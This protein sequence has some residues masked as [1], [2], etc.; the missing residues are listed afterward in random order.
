MNDSGLYNLRL[1]AK[2]KVLTSSVKELQFAGENALVA[3]SEADLQN[4]L[5][6]FARAYQLLRLDL[7]I[8]QTQL[9]YRPA[10]GTSSQ[11]SKIYVENNVL[12]NMDQ[13]A[14]LG[15]LLSTR[16]VIDTEICHLIL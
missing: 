1:R 8:K 7:N 6:Y 14:Y 2:R 15:S 10:T 11:A 16:A 9:L 12:G 4:I 5:D 13:F 3:L